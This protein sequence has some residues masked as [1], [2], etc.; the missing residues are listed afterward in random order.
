MVLNKNL[1]DF[2]QS[3]HF[4]NNFYSCENL[5]IFQSSTKLGLSQIIRCGATQRRQVFVF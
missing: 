4:L 5:E 3:G 2:R 1:G